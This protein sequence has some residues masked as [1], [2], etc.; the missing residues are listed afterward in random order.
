[1]V[2]KLVQILRILRGETDVKGECEEE[3]ESEKQ[4]S[5][6]DDEVYP[7]SCVESHLGVA[8]LDSVEDCTSFSTT[9]MEQRSSRSL[10]EYLKEDADDHIS[11]SFS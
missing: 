9:S 2:L 3:N 5:D 7:E 1:M 6:D 11:F 8:L 10:G 4:V